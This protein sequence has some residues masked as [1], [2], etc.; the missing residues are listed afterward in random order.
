[1]KNNQPDILEIHSFLK[2]SN[3]AGYANPEVHSTNETDGSH[4]IKYAEGD[5]KFHDNYFGGEPFGGREVIFYK[6]KPVFIMVY[7]GSITNF[8]K[9]IDEVYAFLKQA[10]LLG[11]SHE[12]PVRGPMVFEDIRGWKYEF[13]VKGALES[14]SGVE[15]IFFEDK[16]IYEAFVSGG[17]VDT[18]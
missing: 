1:M 3:E 2:R 5:W 7:Y 6:N 4:T 10:L 17:V 12:I 16:C 15:K 18:K 13:E 14:F 11:N 8:V 9:P